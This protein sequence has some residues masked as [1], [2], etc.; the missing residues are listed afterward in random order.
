MWPDAE[1]T[2]PNRYASPQLETLS[3]QLAF[4]PGTHTPGHLGGLDSP[5]PSTSIETHHSTLIT[6]TFPLGL[7]QIHIALL[8]QPPWS[9]RTSDFKLTTG[10]GEFAI[11]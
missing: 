7:T 10:K 4:R 6:N 9:S 11:K 1:G 3:C 8:Y 5:A 2:P